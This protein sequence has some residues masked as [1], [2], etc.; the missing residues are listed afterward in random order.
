MRFFAADLAG[1]AMQP[2]GVSIGAHR[3]AKLMNPRKKK[4]LI[5]Q[6]TAISIFALAAIIFWLFLR[7]LTTEGSPSQDSGALEPVMNYR[8]AHPIVHYRL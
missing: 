2:V 3:P 7:Y 5:Q 1:E 4:R 8:A 6:F